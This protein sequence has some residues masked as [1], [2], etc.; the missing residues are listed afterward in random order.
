MPG[1]CEASPGHPW[2]P[3]P[4]STAPTPA[5]K[6]ALIKG[7]RQAHLLP[8]GPTVGRA[9]PSHPLFPG[10][11]PGENGKQ[12]Q[13]KSSTCKSGKE[14]QSRKHHDLH[15]PSALVQKPTASVPSVLC[16]QSSSRS[17]EKLR[18]G[19]ERKKTPREEC[20]LN[21][22][23]H[24]PSSGVES[25]Q[26]QHSD[27][28]PTHIPQKAL[29]STL[30]RGQALHGLVCSCRGADPRAEARARWVRRGGSAH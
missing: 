15:L 27:L 30:L 17:G 25:E 18:G 19:P 22:R 14:K 7:H 4:G 13:F 28:K 23:R 10:P 1:G 3:A 2:H 24:V 12:S 21:V 11:I 6:Q 8:M 16:P 5:Q 26:S 9:S 20:A 29:L